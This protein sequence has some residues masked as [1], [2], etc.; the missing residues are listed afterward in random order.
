MTGVASR[1]KNNGGW[2]M[3]G[4]SEAPLVEKSTGKIVA[5]ERVQD[6]IDRG[7]LELWLTAWNDKLDGL[8]MEGEH[9]AHNHAWE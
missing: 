6:A 1:E 5:P 4:P 7:D 2:K 8:S 3:I 9:I